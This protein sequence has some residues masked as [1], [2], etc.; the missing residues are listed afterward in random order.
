MLIAYPHVATPGPGIDFIGYVIR[1]WDHWLKGRNSGLMEEPMLTAWMQQSE[2]P[3]ARYAER[4]GR[5][6]AEGNWPNANIAE[7]IWHLSEDGLAEAAGTFARS[8]RSPATVGLASGEWCPYGWGPDMPTDQRE[9]DAGSLCFD[10]AILDRPLQI[11][12]N[13][14]LTVDLASDRTEG[15]LAVRLNDLAPDGSVRRI[16][17][18]LINLQHR[19]GHHRAVELRPGERYRVAVRLKAVGYEL[20]PGHRLRLA[21]STAYWPLAMPAP[22]GGTLT[23]CGGELSL[24]LRGG[25]AA[26]PTELGAAWSPP[27]LDAEVLVRPERGRV[28]IERAGEDGRTT[29]HVV[30]NLGAIRISEVEL[31]LKALGAERYSILPEDPSAARS[32]TERRAEFKRGAWHAAVATRT[33]LTSEG[34]NWRF[35]ADLDAYEGGVRIFARSWDLTIPRSTA[36]GS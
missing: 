21:L 19:D 24:P 16:T 25:D 23:V 32:E 13:A 11:L 7:R 17:Y 6:I 29:V 4:R 20:L 28:R 14:S 8:I 22:D 30:R 1:W 5:W 33:V 27:P 3:R 35:L 2:P 26:K 34:G 18:G 15:L 9:D 10:G 31:A 36:R 12:G